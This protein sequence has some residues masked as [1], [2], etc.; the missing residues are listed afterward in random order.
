MLR[1]RISTLL[2]ALMFVCTAAIPSNLSAAE[3]G[4]DVE[5]SNFYVCPTIAIAIEFARILDRSG[6]EE[7]Y[8]GLTDDEYYKTRDG[9][10]L[11][12]LNDFCTR[13]VEENN[14]TS[15]YVAIRLVYTG[16]ELA[17]KM[18]GAKRNVVAYMAKD[19]DGNPTELYIVTHR[20]FPNDIPIFVSE[21][22]ED[23]E[24]M[25]RTVKKMGLL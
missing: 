15:T 5:D 16:M 18:N 2:I 4:E 21:Q 6:V 1:A 23:D 14:K 25:R 13:I 20:E 24:D 17:F 9:R 12:Q 3:I 7:K 8:S 22:F 11:I 10:R 19:R